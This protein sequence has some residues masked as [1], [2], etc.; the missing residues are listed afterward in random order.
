[1]II[2]KTGALM[3]LA[4]QLPCIVSGQNNESIKKLQKLGIIFGILF[5]ISDDLLGIW[6]NPIKTGKSNYTD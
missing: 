4:F 1:M 5:Q 6:G 3:T 2:K